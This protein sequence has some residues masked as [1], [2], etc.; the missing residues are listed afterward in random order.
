MSFLRLAIGLVC[1]TGSL[2][3]Q[4]EGE[5]GEHSAEAQRRMKA[6]LQAEREGKQ[7][8][9]KEARG[10][11]DDA[12]LTPEQRLARNITN[13][14]SQ[15][16]R[17]FATV[18]PAKLLPGQTGTLRVLATLQGHA[19]L[20][21]PPQLEF[22]G[23]AQ[24]GVVS[25]GPIA[26]QPAAPGRIETGYRGRPVYE[27]FAVI[28]APVTMAANA[29]MGSK[30]IVAMDLKFD[31]Y[32]GSS[33]QPIGRFLDRASTEVQ[34]GSAADPAVQASGPRSA[35]APKAPEVAPP[36]ARPQP[37][38][39][40]VQAHAV[41]PEESNVAKPKPEPDASSPSS[42]SMPL[43]ESAGAVPM[44]VWVG[45]GVLL[46]GFVLLLARRK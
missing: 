44:P 30:H 18:T 10:E 5:T 13:G 2:S 22:V 25:L 24:Q 21:A 7:I 3:C 45:G 42:P 43:D 31:L 1:L 16:C 41:V 32:D 17:F 14:A 26:L 15:Y 23:Q 28:E 35:E 33:A 8:S 6:A 19:V 46:L 27:N 37:A 12:K 36:T 29:V 39:Q 20:Q 4:N 34:V 9:D 11:F 40:P 38:A